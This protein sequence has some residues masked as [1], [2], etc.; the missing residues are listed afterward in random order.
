MKIY[1]IEIIAYFYDPIGVVG[2]WTRPFTQKICHYVYGQSQPPE[3]CICSLPLLQVLKMLS[4][5]PITSL[6]I[7]LCK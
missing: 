3:D 4:F 2:M 5:P 1:F 6:K 7:I